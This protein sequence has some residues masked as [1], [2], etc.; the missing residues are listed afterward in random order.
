MPTQHG[1]SLTHPRA[2]ARAPP[3]PPHISARTL[4][5]DLHGLPAREPLQAHLVRLDGAVARKAHERAERLAVEDDLGRRSL[6]GGHLRH[7]PAVAAARG[8]LCAVAAA[9]AASAV[10]HKLQQRVDGALR[11]RGHG[12]H[13]HVAGR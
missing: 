13:V 4:R 2:S 7:A 9:T 12:E 1:G 3:P 8:S 6:G 5:A 10:V 11:L